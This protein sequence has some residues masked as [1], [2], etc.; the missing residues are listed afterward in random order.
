MNDEMKNRKYGGNMDVLTK[1]QRRKNM[2][3][4]KSK[5]TSIE[6]ALR[7]A[8]W[9]E[10]YRYMGNYKKLPGK[11]DIALVRYKI[12]VFVTANFFMVRTGML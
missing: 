2:Q 11:P 7:K 3:N 6:L 9:R 8:L 5:D 4:I 12:A 10:G 1:E